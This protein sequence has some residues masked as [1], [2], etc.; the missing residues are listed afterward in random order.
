L[1]LKVG[2]DNFS[3]HR[4]FGEVYP[5]QETP[6][7]QLTT[8]GFL[9]RAKELGVDGVSLESIF[10]RSFDSGY[11]AELK[12]PWMVTGLLVVEI[13]FAHPE[14]AGQEDAAVEKSVKYLQKL[15]KEL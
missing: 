13:D 11:L 10:V 3:Y 6:D 15:V 1:T 7:N 4:F 12:A 14:V 8:E 5:Q 2:I 9:K